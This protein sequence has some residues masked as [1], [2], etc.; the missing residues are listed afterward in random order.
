MKRI[1]ILNDGKELLFSY[2]NP[3]YENITDD[4][5][6]SN[7]ILAMNSFAREFGQEKVSSIDLGSE[8]IVYMK[9]TSTKYIF[10]VVYDNK[11][12]IK[13]DSITLPGIKD[14]IIEKY[15]NKS[16]S[17]EIIKQK[18]D[19]SLLEALETSRA[20][21]SSVENFLHML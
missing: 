17:N 16:N 12:D 11:K 1:Y 6:F 10:V 3:S 13:K 15:L 14:F 5:L 21:F 18:I 7:F 19:P 4:T 8:K 2:K 20:K 9:D